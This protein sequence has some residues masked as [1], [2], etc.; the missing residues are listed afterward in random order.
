MLKRSAPSSAMR[1]KKLQSEVVGKEHSSMYRLLGRVYP[2]MCSR[3]VALKTFNLSRENITAQRAKTW[4][5]AWMWMVVGRRNEWDCGGRTNPLLVKCVLPAHDPPAI[6][7]HRS[8]THRHHGP[9]VC[10]LIPS[11]GPA[12]AKDIADAV[13]AVADQIRA[14]C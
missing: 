6:H 12:R 10:Y 1:N 8:P 5:M 3:F 9:A 7:T 13:R 11:L 4:G 14:G 2:P